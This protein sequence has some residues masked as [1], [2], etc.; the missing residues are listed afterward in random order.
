M[1]V[2]LLTITEL[3][4]MY[5]CMHVCASVCE[6]VWE[7]ESESERVSEQANQFKWISIDLFHIP[8]T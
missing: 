4:V 3:Q 2:S 8:Y 5:A 1:W 7:S 6:Y